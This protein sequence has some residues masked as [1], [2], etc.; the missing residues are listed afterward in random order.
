M[1]GFPPTMRGAVTC[2]MGDRAAYSPT[3]FTEP[4]NGP[5]GEFETP[6]SDGEMAYGASVC[7]GAVTEST[8]I[9]MQDL[10][11]GEQQDLFVSE[12]SAA[13]EGADNRTIG[14]NDFDQTN[15][16]V[17]GLFRNHYGA[18]RSQAALSIVREKL[19]IQ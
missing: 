7:D 8:T 14:L 2:E 1:N 6:C 10:E 11:D 12:T 13:L 5:S 15:Y 4:L 3:H 19:G 16:F 18:V 17:C 9:V